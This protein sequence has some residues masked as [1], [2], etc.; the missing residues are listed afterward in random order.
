[1]R[2][3][4]RLRKLGILALRGRCAQ[5]SIEA[6][7]STMTDS[8]PQD[9]RFEFGANWASFARDLSDA[10]IAQ[11]ERSLRSLLGGDLS[12]QTFLDIGCGSGLSS[13]AALRLGAASV[14]ALD[15]DPNSVAT[16][17]S[18]LGL[19]AAGA[20]WTVRQQSVFDLDPK[21]DGRFDV[22]YSWGVLHHTG[23]MWQA[24]RKAAA[25]VDD[26]GRFVV[27]IYQRTYLC[28]FWTWE[29]RLYNR[30]PAFVARAIRGLYKSLFLAAY[31]LTGRNPVRYVRDYGATR[32][33]SW[34]HDVHDWL[35]GYPYESATSEEIDRAMRQLGFR[36]ETYVPC[37]ITVGLFSS[38]CNEYVYRRIGA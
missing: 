36:R 5:A 6:R 34:T 31:A 38:G 25:L 10:R 2:P 3:L 29:K 19:H 8:T 22:V 24:I 26:G 28:G 35:G 1:M 33:M 27:A 30:V 20:K 7:R 12:N 21:T 4:E 32:G 23:G 15:L 13:L 14:L 11:A 17:Q 37:G 18:V 9:E 16:A